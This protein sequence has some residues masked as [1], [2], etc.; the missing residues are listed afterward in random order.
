[1]NRSIVFAAIATALGNAASAGAYSITLKGTSLRFP[2]GGMLEGGK[3]ARTD[4][5]LGRSMRLH[6]V[7]TWR[8]GL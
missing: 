7:E 2:T 8:S 4:V 6:H 5:R 3:E 1:M